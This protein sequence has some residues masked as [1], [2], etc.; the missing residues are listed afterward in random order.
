MTTRPTII[1]TGATGRT[2]NAVAH[3]LASRDDVDIDALVAPSVASGTPSRPLPAGVRAFATL[4]EALVT[5][6]A[7]AV[8]V[9]LTHADAAIAH[10]ELALGAGRH[11]V[12]GTTG[13]ADSTLEELGDR[14][15]EAGLALLHVPNF[16]LG[17]VLSI[18][19]ATQVA[20]FFPDVEIVE[21]HH[22]GKRDSPS[23]TAVH[24][25]RAIAAARRDA[26]LAP[27]HGAAAAGDG[28]G[29][30]ESIEGVPVHALRLPGATAHEEIV[31]GAPGELL[32]IRHD[33]IDRSCY[34]AGVV[35]AARRAPEFTGLTT[36][37]ETLL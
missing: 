35:L 17:A 1:L 11:L 34:A 5:A 4:A 14:F 33:A 24:T 27:G 6:P 13:I 19:L 18:R 16:S 10:A 15:A 8:I 28:G 20:A 7:D 3:A 23:G 9:D 37:L 31:F 26:G 22:D 36:G 12:L 21:T 29:R 25:A 30:G 2:G 32:T